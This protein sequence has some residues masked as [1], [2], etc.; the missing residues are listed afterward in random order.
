M[1]G[2]P[3]NL[4]KRNREFNQVIK[5]MG[6]KGL[7]KDITFLIDIQEHLEHVEFD[8]ECIKAGMDRD[9]V[10]VVEV[11][12]Y[13]NVSKESMVT[14]LDERRKSHETTKKDV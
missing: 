11:M 4:C 12:K 13:F 14:F 7:S 9:Y 5:H 2:C 3:C 1:A 6:E 10:S 8:L